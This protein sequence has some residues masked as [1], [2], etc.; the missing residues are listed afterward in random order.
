[1]MTE[2]Q[3]TDESKQEKPDT[4]GD[5][6]NIITLLSLYIIQGV[7]SGLPVLAFPIILQNRKISYADQVRSIFFLMHWK[8]NSNSMAYFNSG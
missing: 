3:Q 1:M 7:V 4:K 2:L 6:V 5:K 8:G